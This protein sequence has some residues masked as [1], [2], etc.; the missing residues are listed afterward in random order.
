[1]NVDEGECSTGRERRNSSECLGTSPVRNH[2]R[3]GR[4]RRCGRIPSAM[5]STPAIDGRRT[6]VRR[7]A[8][9]AAASVA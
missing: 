6:V 9:D 7:R 4:L 2:G 1:M 8:C 5:V 3:R